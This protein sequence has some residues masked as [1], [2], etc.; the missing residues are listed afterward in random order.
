M[1]KITVEMYPYGSEE[2]KYLLS[3]AKIWN[4]GKGTNRIGQYKG[5]FFDHINNQIGSDIE[6]KDFKRQELDMWDLIY[7]GIEALRRKK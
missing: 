6:V 4:T 1:L 2:N 5:R 3:T 7:L